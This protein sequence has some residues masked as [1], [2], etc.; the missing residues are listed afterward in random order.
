MTNIFKKSTGILLTLLII[1]SVMAVAAAGSTAASAADEGDIVYFEKPSSWSNTPNVHIWGGSSTQTSWP[2]NKMTLVEGNV[3]SYTFTGNYK[4]IIFNNGSGSYQTAD[5]DISEGQIFKITS[6]D[7]TSSANGEWSDYDSPV[8]ILSVSAAPG[9]TTFTDTLDITLKIKNA[10]EA[11]YSIN[12]GDKISCT[13]GQVISIG[14]EAK[15]GEKINLD[16]SASDGTNTVNKSYVYTKA[17]FTGAYVYLNNEAGWS[18]C[19]IYYWNGGKNNGWPGTALTDADMDENGYYV[20]NIPQEYVGNVIFNNG[21]EQSE[22]LVI[23]AGESMIYNNKTKTWEIFD[24]GA[25]Q[26]KNI[27]TSVKSPQYT[28]TDIDIFAQATGGSGDISY[29]FS[30]ESDNG[31]VVLSDYSDVSSVN[32]NPQQAGSYKIIIEVKDTEGNSNSRKIDFVIQDDKISEKPV[33]KGITADPTNFD[34][35][36][37]KLNSE[38]NINVK[39]SGGKI[40]T[41]LLFYKTEIFAPGEDTAMNTPY[42]KLDNNFTFTPTKLGVYKIKISVQN[43]HNS[44]VTKTYEYECVNEFSTSDTPKINKFTASKS[45]SELMVDEAITFEAGAAGGLE[46]YTYKFIVTNSDTSEKVEE[47]ADKN[48]FTW[49]PKEAGNYA[50]TA[51][52]SDAN[53]KESSKTLYYQVSDHAEDMMGD[54]NFDGEVDLKDI[55]LIQKEMAELLTFS[56]RQRAVADVN[57]DGAVDLK[58]IL[59]IQKYMA[60]L[61]TTFD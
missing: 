48:V 10:T 8:K 36:E 1:V 35:T 37:I 14:Q 11:Y 15:D 4:K 60:E 38:T 18:T 53:G 51:Y 19:N 47:L 7:T 57:R 46:P 39:A 32:W 33:L 58:D 21:S 24:A 22:D 42:Y 28:D 6:G 45:G 49:T 26:F 30:V 52:V 23:N 50:V 43:S 44:T 3:Y 5:L 25:I 12:G 20:Y 29:K 31:T 61:I 34:N 9:T 2:G 59:Q 13:D 17:S 41:N 27:G 56:D 16:I 55:L 54:I 40:G